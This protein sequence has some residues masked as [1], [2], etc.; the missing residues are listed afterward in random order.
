M[1]LVHAVWLRILGAY[2]LAGVITYYLVPRCIAVAQKFNILD[3]PNGTVKTHASPTAYLGGVAVYLGFLV[4]VGLVFPFD[5]QFFLFFI[6]STILFFVG[7]ADDLMPLSPLQKFIGQAL[8]VICFLKG[9]IYVKAHIL[10]DI[11]MILFSALWM[12]FVINTINL[13][14]IMDGLATTVALFCSG[15]FFII[16]LMGYQYTIALLLAVFMG[17]LMAF[18]VFNAPRASI[19]QGDAGSL[20]IGGILSVIPFLIN[21]GSLT[22]YGFL[23]PL[24]IL[25]IPL[26]EGTFLIVI[27]T[28]KGIPFY[29]P[30][31]DHFAIKLKYQG[32]SPQQVLF[33]V[34]CASLVLMIVAI[35]FV[36][37]VISLL[38]VAIMGLLFATTWTFCIYIKKH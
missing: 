31:P 30:S 4:A 32:F 12:L 37:E 5:N 11:P 10:H 25:A 9:G 20:F 38:Q 18:L 35:G 27:R 36:A 34:C 13:I 3:H 8:A 22:Y 14:D 15:A 16:A 6:G 21:W 23:A 2:A 33:L 19:Y 29:R 24:I 1:M 7:L 17:N 28:Y 26:L